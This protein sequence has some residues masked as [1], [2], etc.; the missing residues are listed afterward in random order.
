MAAADVPFYFEA[1]GGDIYVALDS[2][3]SGLPTVSLE[4][5]SN[6]T[7]GWTSFPVDGTK[8]QVQDGHRIYLRAGAS[9]NAG[10][11]LDDENYRHFEIESVVDE[12]EMWPGEG[13]VAACASGGNIMSLLSRS[14]SGATT[15]PSEYCFSRLFYECDRMTSAPL[16]P[17]TAL[18][19]SC[20]ERMFLECR[21]L[22]SA[23]DLSH[24]A[25]LDDYCCS[26]MFSGCES[27]FGAASLPAAS[28][29]GRNPLPM[30]SRESK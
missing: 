10:F 13:M 2:V 28:V 29:K 22:T 26:G 17:A 1:T 19:R 4:Q 15:I 16:L 21:E 8:V 25:T 6:G 18:R 20:Y 27:M 30:E 24:V 23:P 14:F 12:S 11:S 7:S 3:G 5:S 9:G